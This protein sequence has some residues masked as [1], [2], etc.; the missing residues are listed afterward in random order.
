MACDFTTFPRLLRLLP[1]RLLRLS[2]EGLRLFL[3]PADRGGGFHRGGVGAA[4][5]PA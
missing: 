3:F 2:G 1:E 5:V 4:G